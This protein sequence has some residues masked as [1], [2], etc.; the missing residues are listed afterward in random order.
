MKIKPHSFFLTPSVMERSDITDMAEKIPYRNA[1]RDRDK[2]TDLEHRES[3]KRMRDKFHQQT[4]V[5]T[6]RKSGCHLQIPYRFA[7]RDRDKYNDLEHRES[8]KRMRDKF[9]QQIYIHYVL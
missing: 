4:Y 1:V 2:Y 6:F 3:R 7:A 5:T 8:R 9:S